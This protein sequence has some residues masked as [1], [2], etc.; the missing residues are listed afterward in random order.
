[1]K[2]RAVIFDTE[3][4]GLLDAEGDRVIELGGVEIVGNLITGR[5]FHEYVNPGSRKVDR[6][7]YEVHGISDEFLADKPP[8]REVMP[9]F[10]DFV[11]DSPIVIHNAP[12]DMRFMNMETDRLKIARIGNE[13][14]D[15]LTLARKL[16]PTSRNNLDAL[17]N[18]Y[19]I[20]RSQR[21]FHGA[22]L[23]AD[24]LAQVYINM[25]GLNRLDLG[26]R[27]I[28]GPQAAGAVSAMLSAG[29]QARPARPYRPS[30]LPTEEE[31]QG[32]G[33]FVDKKIK[34]P[35]WARFH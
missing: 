33:L 14:V 31:M 22:L 2:D 18:R 21:K 30:L 5:T 24:L 3:T 23:D 7:A 34:D 20:D 11:G 32:H 27:P 16:F 28:F 26:D 10:L 6:E 29:G 9:R 1:M 25:L 35:I 12:F 4:T 17:C 19:N 8:M 13:I 15:T